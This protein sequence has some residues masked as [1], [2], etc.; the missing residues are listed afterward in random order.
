[1]ASCFFL[2]FE[3]LCTSLS[4]ALYNWMVCP[5]S[6]ESQLPTLFLHRSKPASL[7]FQQFLKM[8]CNDGFYHGPPVR[9][10]S[11]PKPHNP[12]AINTAKMLPSAEPATMKPISQALDA[13]F[14]TASAGAKAI[15]VLGSDGR[16]EVHLA[17][18]SLDL[19]HA[20]V[21][22]GVS[23]TGT[24]TL[25]ISEMSGHFIGASNLLGTYQVQV[26]DSKGWPVSGIQ[27]T[28]SRMLT[29]GM[30]SYRVPTTGFPARSFYAGAGRS[31]G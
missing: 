9:P 19:S 6:A 26:V 22:G 15:D 21:A 18:G 17:R 10:A 4:C 2:F 30:V 28:P 23:P 16:L 7:T 1:M 14:L 29:L 25:Q 20:T 11:Y 27:L 31:T 12:S 5:S 13:A 24:L 3:P 8:R